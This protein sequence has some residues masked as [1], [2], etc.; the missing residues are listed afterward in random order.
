[1]AAAADEVPDRCCTLRRCHV[2]GIGQVEEHVDL[3]R[4]AFAADN[5]DRQADFVVV[6]VAAAVAASVDSVHENDAVQLEPP[7]A[8][9]FATK[10]PWRLTQPA[11]EFE[12]RE[13]D[14]PLAI[15]PKSLLLGCL[16][17]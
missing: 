3:R 5:L 7:A 15:R 9:I 11:T 10:R 16:N 13:E 6:V 1:M 12:R 2:F 4:D 8:A 17:Q 14:F